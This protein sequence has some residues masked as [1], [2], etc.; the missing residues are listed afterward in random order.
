MPEL[1][2][3]GL[4]VEQEDETV[5]E[6]EVCGN[7][8]ETLVIL[9]GVWS[10]LEYGGVPSELRVQMLNHILSFA[11]AVLFNSLM[12]RGETSKGL[13]ENIRDN[14]LMNGHKQNVKCM[15]SLLSP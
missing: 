1:L 6:D 2:D 15:K 13:M 4:E 10:A 14:K 3:G 11:N 8:R 12:E 7:E 5:V 9:K